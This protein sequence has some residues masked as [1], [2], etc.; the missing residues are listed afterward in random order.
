MYIYIYIYTRI[1]IYTYHI[2]IYLY[3]YTY[4]YIYV[5]HTGLSVAMW[6]LPARSPQGGT[7]DETKLRHRQSQSTPG[8]GTPDATGRS[9]EM[10]KV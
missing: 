3:L 1:Y 5:S 4:I 2:Y 9:S 7:G 6:D 10:K 8:N